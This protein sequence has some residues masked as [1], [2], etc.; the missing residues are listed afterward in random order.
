M[1]NHTIYE[2]NATWRGLRTVFLSN[3]TI[4]LCGPNVLLCL[5]VLHQHIK[6]SLFFFIYYPSQCGYISLE[7]TIVEFPFCAETNLSLTSDAL[8]IIKVSIETFA[9]LKFTFAGCKMFLA[10][11]HN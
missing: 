8:F 2:M 7:V 1:C 6:K 11:A 10:L 5:V 4:C 3:G 9:V